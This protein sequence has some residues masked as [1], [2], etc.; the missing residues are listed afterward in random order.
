ME[1]K[2]SLLGKGF[3]D[4]KNYFKYAEHLLQII[5]LQAYKSVY[6]HLITN[7][8]IITYKTIYIYFF[9]YMTYLMSLI[10]YLNNT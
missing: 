1:I 8:Y 6:R 5:Y 10:T 7:Y 2:K 9:S 4:R 3:C